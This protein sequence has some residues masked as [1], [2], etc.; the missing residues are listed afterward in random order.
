MLVAKCEAQNNVFMLHPGPG[1]KEDNWYNI[2]M[3]QD[4]IGFLNENLLFI[5]AMTGFHTTSTIH[6]HGKK[7]ALNVLKK[8]PELAKDMLV[9]NK[10]HKS[11]DQVALAGEKFILVLYG[12]LQCESLD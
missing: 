2:S 6:K 4:K 9:F 10:I 7:K 12:G 3:I 1:L 8:N 5:H 11:T